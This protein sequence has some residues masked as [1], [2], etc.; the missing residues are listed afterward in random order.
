MWK[1]CSASNVTRTGSD[2]A[3]ERLI[4]PPKKNGGR[5]QKLPTRPELDGL[6]EVA[7]NCDRLGDGL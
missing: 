3:L 5:D 1:G 6:P 2:F 7:L 4:S